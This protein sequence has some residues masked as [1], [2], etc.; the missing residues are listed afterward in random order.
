[1]PW[2]GWIAIGA[3]ML[4][5]ELAFVDADF[6]LVFLGVSAL[7]VGG[8]ELSGV[9][10]AWW[11]QWL[12]FAGLSVGSLIFFRQRVYGL[13]RPPPEDEIAE[14]VIGDVARAVAAIA[15]GATGRV[16][17]RGSPWSAVNEGPETIPA[18]GRCDVIGTEGLT[19]R[20]RAEGRSPT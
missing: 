1:M 3:L 15:P 6:Y 16:E 13:F 17:L 11:A 9:T 19:V 10:L 12:V 2:W 20:V 7:L 8:F 5:A 4:A 18:G 14:G